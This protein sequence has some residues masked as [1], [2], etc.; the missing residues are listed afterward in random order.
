MILCRRYEAECAHRLTAGVPETHK[1]RRPHG[2][3]YVIWIAVE[4]VVGDDGM[5]IEYGDMDSCVAQTIRVIDHHDLNT[6]N[7]R[8]S[9]SE[10]ARVAENPTVERLVEWIAAR[11]RLLASSRPG[12]VKGLAFVRVEEDSR[13]WVEWRP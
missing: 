9:T 6:L 5:L 2:H 1:C 3:R 8:C 13:S 7:E 12:Y 10:A 4:G 11:V